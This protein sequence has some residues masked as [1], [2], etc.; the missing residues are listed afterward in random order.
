MAAGYAG[1]PSYRRQFAAMGVDPEDPAEIVRRVILT[2]AGDAVARLD[3]YRDAGADLPIVYPL[4]PAG[5]P[6]PGLARATLAP[7]AP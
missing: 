4:L 5:A 6:D 1:H 3:A 2:R 7:F